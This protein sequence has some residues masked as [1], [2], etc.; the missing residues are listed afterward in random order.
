MLQGSFFLSE[1]IK[2][3]NLNH[4]K[5]IMSNVGTPEEIAVGF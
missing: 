5:P 2:P 1:N 4:Y 3:N